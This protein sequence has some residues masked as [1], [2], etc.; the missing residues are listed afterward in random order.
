MEPSRCSWDFRGEMMCLQLEAQVRGII[1]G[2]SGDRAEN[3]TK[4][5]ALG[6]SRLRSW[7]TRSNQR[8]SMRRSSLWGGRWPRKGR[9]PRSQDKKVCQGERAQLRSDA[10]GRS[11][12]GRLRPRDCIR[13][14]LT[15]TRTAGVDAD[16]ESLAG[17]SPREKGR[18]GNGD[19]EQKSPFQRVLL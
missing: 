17:G 11:Q 2:M 3:G 15:L 6:A 8:S 14:L 18:K 7:A 5:G 10:A 12:K 19:V 16:N 13:R 4:D 9:C 1:K